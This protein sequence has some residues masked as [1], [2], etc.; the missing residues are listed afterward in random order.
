VSA[1]G[2]HTLYA[3]SKDSEGNKETPVNKCATYNA[4]TN[5]F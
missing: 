4:T 5:T 2:Q 1:D 3:A